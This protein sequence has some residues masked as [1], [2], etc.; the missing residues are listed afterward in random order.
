MDST[1]DK[2]ISHFIDVAAMNNSLSS[3][4]TC[5]VTSVSGC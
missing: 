3:L 5:E 1:D 4:C 2:D